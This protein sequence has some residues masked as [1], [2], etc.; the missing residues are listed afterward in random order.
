MGVA[1]GSKTDSLD[2]LSC[3]EMALKAG[4]ERQ[5]VASAL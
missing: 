1:A 4:V 5:R 2:R 3:K